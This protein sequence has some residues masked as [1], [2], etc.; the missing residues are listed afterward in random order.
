LIQKQSFID[1]SLPD[2]ALSTVL[3]YLHSLSPVLISLDL[4]PN[5]FSVPKPMLA[6]PLP[7]FVQLS[8]G[9]RIPLSEFTLP[10]HLE[11][12]ANTRP[13]MIAPTTYLLPRYLS[14]ALDG[15]SVLQIALLLVTRPAS[16][17]ILSL[18]TI[19]FFFSL[20]CPFENLMEI[21]QGIEEDMKKVLIVI[22]RFK[23]RGPDRSEESNEEKPCWICF[24][25]EFEP[26]HVPINS[27]KKRCELPRCG[28]QS[29]QLIFPEHP[30]DKSS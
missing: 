26:P 18:S 2:Q 19:L 28:H 29:K 10:S 7:H 12:I 23:S 30:S 11:K 3:I 13:P 9:H 6:P 20:L 8:S 25:E 21:R 14:L 1:P 17:R 27:F 4:L 15:I 5:S 22:D 16:F 24:E